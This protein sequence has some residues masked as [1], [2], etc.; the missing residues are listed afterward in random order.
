MEKRIT[1]AIIIAISMNV[2]GQLPT[3]GLVG[4]WP[5]NGNANDESGNGNN[6]SV[7]GATLT[8][9]RLGN[10][11]SA[12]NFNFNYIECGYASSLILPS[13]LTIGA[14]V[15][16]SNSTQI[17]IIAQKTYSLICYNGSWLGDCW[18]GVSPMN[19]S[20][21]S[22]VVTD[23]WVF[24][25][26]TY[27]GT[28]MSIY[29]DGQLNNTK[30][31]TGNISTQNNYPLRIGA[32]SWGPGQ[33][34]RGAIDEVF[35][36]NRALTSE[37]VQ[38]VYSQTISNILTID[39]N[40]ILKVFPNPTKDYITID[41]GNYL[42]FNAVNLKITNSI[43]VTLFTK[44]INEKTININLKGINGKGIYFMQL[45]DENN[46]TLALKKIVLN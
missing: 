32:N 46:N 3:N 31:A 7:V 13:A 44:T 35:I 30:A 8:N 19:V 1:I 10:P 2:F 15:K 17:G 25:V 12:Y 29:I 18:G 23:K 33:Y 42:N 5:F 34:F 43:G 27:S 24:I 37:E 14:W 21:V 45:T 4:Y 38:A 39:N 11:N 40:N 22:S 9:D 6:G 26:Y 28:N 41:L 20:S 36:Y 16:P